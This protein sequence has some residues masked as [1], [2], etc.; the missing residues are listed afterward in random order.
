MKRTLLLLGAGSSIE[1]GVPSTV[2]IGK[3]IECYLNTC[4]YTVSTS[5]N[6]VYQ[7]IKSELESYLTSP[8]DVNFEHT[9]VNITKPITHKA[10]FF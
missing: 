4:E 1:G 6:R 7:T 9:V 3:R 5:A 8:E 2:D 10:M